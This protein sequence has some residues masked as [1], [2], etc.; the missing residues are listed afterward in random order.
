[1]KNIVIT[2][3]LFSIV[4][5]VYCQQQIVPRNFSE[6]DQITISRETGFA[7][8]IKAIEVI[9]QQS[10]NR[11]IVNMSTFIGEIRIPIKQ[12]YWK[13]AL[14][15]IVGFNNLVIDERPGAFIIKDIEVKEVKKPEDKEVVITAFTRQVRISSIFFKADKT[16]SN[17]IGINW[18][19]LIGG[20]V[21]ADIKFSGASE[22]ESDLFQASISKNFDTGNITIDVDALL[23]IIE[24]Y[25]R[26]AIIARPSI[27][28]LS[29]KTGFVQVGQDFS[30]KTI[31]EAGN[32]I[33]KFFETG[34]ILEVTPKILVEGDREV[35]HLKV[36]VEKS[37]AIPGQISTIINKSKSSTDIILYDGEET[38]IGGLYDTDTKIER[39]GIPILK[40]LPW[41]FFGLRYLFGY[42]S[43]E[44][45][46][47][48]MI[49]ILKVELIDSIEKRR[50]DAIPIMDILDREE[51]LNKRS[52]I[53]F[54]NKE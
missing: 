21:N 30:V 43:H 9:S 27:I 1:M 19:T 37:S 45:S 29:G 49:I 24:G 23:R 44:V 52:Q 8:A 11:K 31:D 35:I 13:D 36:K 28:V 20:K 4:S 16:L 47:N 48:E 32:V 38:V 15:L 14:S 6:K 33:D 39:S 18:T 3:I 53:I 22:I 12:L 46:T 54:K 50:E 5:L 10:E 34:H 17:Q 42:S 51:L 26:G 41:W 25:Q 2:F 40:D 7:E